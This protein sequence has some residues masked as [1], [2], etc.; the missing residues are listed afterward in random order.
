[1]SFLTELKEIIEPSLQTNHG[2]FRYVHD[3]STFIF[4]EL[5]KIG[6]DRVHHID[7]DMTKLTFSTIDAALRTHLITF[8]LPAQYPLVPPRLTG[9]HLPVSMDITSCSHLQDMLNQHQSLINQYQPL[10][11]CMDDL[12][13]HMRILEPDHPTR[14]DCWRRIA[15][16]H[17][18]SLEI[19]LNPDM[20]RQN[21][22]KVR[23]FGNANRV[24]ELKQLWHAKTWH[25]DQPIHTNLLDL[26]QVTGDQSESSVNDVECGICYAYKLNGTDT[27]DIIC[28][29]CNR[30]FHDEC[31]YQ[32]SVEM[33]SLYL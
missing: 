27:P 14:T 26:C 32:V 31:L 7:Q 21:K 24:H 22:P 6:F 30:G 33:T 10:F 8:S 13:Q 5:V 28:A 4:N 23:F 3:R 25:Q 11:D 19:E 2:V 12:D 20:P 9:Y 18:C 29:L 17:H 1:M 15:L 16:G